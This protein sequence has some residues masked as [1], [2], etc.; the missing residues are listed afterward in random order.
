MMG[1]Q[2]TGAGVWVDG[3]MGGCFYTHT[4][5]CTLRHT[6]THNHQHHHHDVKLEQTDCFKISSQRE[7]EVSPWSLNIPQP[8]E[9]MQRCFG[10]LL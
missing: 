10:G 9:L 1:W 4:K 8:W 2:N 5:T 3:E 6:H 7:D